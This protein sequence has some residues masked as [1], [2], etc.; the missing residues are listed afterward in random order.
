MPL[1]FDTLESRQMFAAVP[2][3]SF[4]QYWIELVNRARNSP[5]LE[6]AR[7]GID[8]N[9]GLNAGTIT[10]TAKAPLANNAFLN[11]SA[12]LHAFWVRTNEQISL[13]GLNGTL[14]IDRITN[15]GYTLSG[16][17]QGVAESVDAIVNTAQPLDIAAVNEIHR[18]LFL[19]TGVL[20]R[21]NRV[22]MLSS[23]FR[24]VGAGLDQGAW[25]PAGGTA[26]QAVAAVMDF[27]LSTGN[28]GGDVFLTGVAY[29]DADGDNFYTPNAGNGEGL[30]N[31][32]VTARRLSDGATFTTATFAS[33][34]YSLRLTPGTYEVTATGGSLGNNNAVIYPAVVIG[35]QNVKRDFTTQQVVPAPVNPGTGGPS[36]PNPVTLKGDIKGKV[37]FD[38]AGLRIKQDVTY[39]D[40]VVGTVVYVDLNKNGSRNTNEPFGRVLPNTNLTGNGIYNITGLDPGVY[41]LRVEPPSGYRVSIPRST[42]Y[43]VRVTSGKVTKPKAFAITEHTLISGRVYRDANFNGNFDKDFDV[44]LR[45]WRV[46]IDL[47]NDSIWQRETE[48]STR[49]EPDGYYAF[50]DLLAGT[51]TIRVIAKPGYIQTEPANNGAYVVQLNTSS[52][53]DIIN[54]DFGQRL[55]G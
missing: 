24:E 20:N 34:G 47:N 7:Y 42:F 46:F 17:A 33:G 22:S 15:A 55:I 37:R 49:S 23:G 9:E 40:A 36:T 50:R 32:T 13:V 44:G 35:S 8:L 19:D 38:R 53:V 18:R 31:V 5:Q 3:T 43:E 41:E 10:T 6:A 2:P 39:T 51:Y 21:T 12:G 30:G 29:N 14:P 26:A 4:E 1:L 28:A 25:T 54:Q 48:P 27:A 16:T 52:G 45:D 11:D